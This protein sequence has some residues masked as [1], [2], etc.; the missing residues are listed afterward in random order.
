MSDEASPSPKVAKKNRAAKKQVGKAKK[1]AA[2]DGTTAKGKPW[3][4]PRNTLED[5]IRIPKA[6]EDKNAGIRCPPQTLRRQLVSDLRMIGDFS[7]PSS[8]RTNTDWLSALGVM[9]A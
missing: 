7:T 2:G 4:F 1:A 8:Q 9:S 3:T 5:A 6:I